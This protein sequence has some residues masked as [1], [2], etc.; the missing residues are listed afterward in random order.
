MKI[1]KLAVN[2]FR[3]L[4]DFR[5]EFD[6]ELTVVVGEN[7]AG[8]SSLIEC[9]KVI[10]QGRT[11]ELDD[12]NHDLPRC[13]DSCRLIGFIKTKDRGRKERCNA[14]LFTRT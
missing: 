9:L 5:V 10:T 12:F 3:C 6:E 2:G 7:D 14:A 11:I 4:L 13:Q 1:R 8:K